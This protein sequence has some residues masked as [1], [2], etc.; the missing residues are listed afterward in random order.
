MR[1]E[2]RELVTRL[3]GQPEDPHGLYAE[4]AHTLETIATRKHWKRGVDVSKMTPEH[5]EKFWAQ[6]DRSGGPDACWPWKGRCN[7]D[8]Y[9]HCWIPGRST[10]VRAHRVA[11]ALSGK[12]QPEGMEADHTC[13]TRPC[14][15][16]KHIEFVSPAENKKRS[17]APHQ[18][19]ARKTE[20]PRGH[21]LSGSNLAIWKHKEKNG[22]YTPSRGC[23]T[24]H[25]GYWMWA[26]EERPGPPKARTK[27]RGPFRAE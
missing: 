17:N 16:P 15:N 11:C 2:I 19:N 9:G 5:I 3:R 1:T 12:P 10:D 20:C 25:P 4:A 27:W 26:V 7:H 24:C 6:V 23:L 13:G 21:P 8:G 18:L 22:T 14:C